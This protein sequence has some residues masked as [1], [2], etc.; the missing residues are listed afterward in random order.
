M[1][2]F[3]ISSLILA[4]PFWLHEPPQSLETPV[5]ENVQFDCL[6]GGTPKP[7][8]QWMINGVPIKGLS[9]LLVYIT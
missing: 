8:V 2:F 1:L 3:K 4:M 5:G 7:D 6:V 9:M